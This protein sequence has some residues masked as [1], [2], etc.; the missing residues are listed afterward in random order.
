MYHFTLRI[1]FKKQWL[2]VVVSI[3]TTKCYTFHYLRICGIVNNNKGNYLTHYSWIVICD[4]ALYTKDFYFRKSS[5]LSEYRSFE[6]REKFRCC[7]WDIT[8]HNSLGRKRSVS[9]YV[10][11][12]KC[13]TITYSPF[14]TH[15]T[16]ATSIL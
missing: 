13:I 15:I 11:D 12:K 16:K 1:S 4:E 6:S 3:M 14:K 7:T 5:V 8:L 9:L 10:L 2:S